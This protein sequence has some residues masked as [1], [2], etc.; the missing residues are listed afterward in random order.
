[1]LKLE[2]ND[3]LLVRVWHSY[4]AYPTKPCMLVV[5]FLWPLDGSALQ[6]FSCSI[7]VLMLFCRCASLS[8]SR[9]EPFLRS[10]S[11]GQGAILDHQVFRFRKSFLFSIFRSNSVIEFETKIVIKLTFRA[12][13]MFNSCI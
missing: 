6:S 8:P 7:F 10:A 3:L 12:F 5:G 2:T 11:L 4:R 13:L 1:M 9:C